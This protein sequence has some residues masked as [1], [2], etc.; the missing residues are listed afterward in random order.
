MIGAQLFNSFFCLHIIFPREFLSLLSSSSSSSPT[1]TCVGVF[2]KSSLLDG[3]NKV[4]FMEEL[5]QRDAFLISGEEEEEEDRETVSR[6]SKF[7]ETT[8]FTFTRD[9]YS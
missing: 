1:L 7:W 5:L 2:G 9:Y 3:G 8:F 4:R 6:E